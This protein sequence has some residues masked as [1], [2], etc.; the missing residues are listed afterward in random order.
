ERLKAMK[1][2]SGTLTSLLVAAGFALLAWATPAVAQYSP[3]GWM[4]VVGSHPLSVPGA[5]AK[6]SRVR[7]QAAACGINVQS[8]RS[9]ELIANV[10]PN[11]AVMFV[12]PYRTR[13][14]AVAALATVRACLPD[15]YVTPGID[16]VAA[17]E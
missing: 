1:K 5:G 10:A 2:D 11:R 6:A 17:T 4:V 7:L 14:Q 12:G 13:G 8:G 15:A 16:A 9:D 3:A